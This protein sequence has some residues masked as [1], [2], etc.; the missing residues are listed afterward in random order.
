MD[1]SHKILIPHF[2]PVPLVR[3]RHDGWTPARQR[4]FLAALVIEHVINGETRPRFYPPL[5]HASH[6]KAA[7]GSK[8]TP[9]TLPV[10]QG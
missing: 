5:C 9:F 7:S 1:E 2:T 4:I 10:R 3:S 8:P 6:Q